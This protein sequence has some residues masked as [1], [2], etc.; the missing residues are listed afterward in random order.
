MNWY[1][2]Y[3]SQEEGQNLTEIPQWKVFAGTNFWTCDLPN[4]IFDLLLAV[5]VFLSELQWNIFLKKSFWSIEI[6]TQGWWLWSSNSISVLCSSTH[7][8]QQHCNIVSNQMMSLNVH[9]PGSSSRF[10]ASF[11]RESSR[12]CSPKHMLCHRHNLLHLQTE[13]KAFSSM[14]EHLSLFVPVA[15]ARTLSLSITHTHTH[16]NYSQNERDPEFVSTGREKERGMERYRGEREGVRVEK[17]THA[18]TPMHTHMHTHAHA[19][20]HSHTHSNTL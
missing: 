11:E 13:L 4:Q 18:R 7:H 20:A 1:C 9:L 17:G 6:R 8:T 12:F 14:S 10:W 15:H 5:S 16:T 3:K 19:H 2:E